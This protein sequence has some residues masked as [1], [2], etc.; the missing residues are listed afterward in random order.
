MPHYR[1]KQVDVFS[2]E[3]LM[4]NPLAVV[5]DAEGIDTD[6]M[7]AF[8]RWTNLSETAFVVPPVDPLADYR[9]RI[10]NTK[11][12]M[13]FA[14]HPT[15]GSCHAWLEAGGQS[16]GNDIVQEC[17]IGLVR[18]RR[19]DAVLSF[20]APALRRSTRLDDAL[21][22]RI[23]LGL[24][25]DDADIVDA[26]WVDNGANW[27]AVVL[28]DRR[29]VLALRPDAATLEGL[30]IG[31]I[32]PWPDGDAQFEIRA[33]VFAGG[34]LEDA[35]TGSLNAGVAQWF[36]SD[37]LAPDRYVVAQGTCLGRACRLT[38]AKESG[39]LWIGGETITCIE[40]TSLFT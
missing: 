17:G 31:V 13:E 16:K 24:A 20:A 10:F 4:G 39:E 27:M 36:T 5:L 15:L 25:L 26:R 33:F 37:G 28:R 32:A 1:F 7:L 29:K 3:P 21:R 6:T 9:L 34:M 30:K 18:I 19:A 38:I 12:E 40:G 35:A 22:D 14:G 11:G 8:A 2:S 23:R